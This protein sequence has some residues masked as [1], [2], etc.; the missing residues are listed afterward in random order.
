MILKLLVDDIF[1]DCTRA[2]YC[3]FQKSI[4]IVPVFI[5]CQIFMEQ[6]GSNLQSLLDQ[7]AIYSCA[8]YR[9]E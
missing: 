3:C 8:F 7:K 4:L 1:E 9:D 2:H 6:A 5:F